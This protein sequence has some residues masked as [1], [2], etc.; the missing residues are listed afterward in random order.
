MDVVRV[1]SGD[2]RARL[3]VGPQRPTQ[4]ALPR[5]ASRSRTHRTVAAGWRTPEL[6]PDTA[7]RPRD[8]GEDAPAGADGQAD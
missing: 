1:C 7:H 2:R 3:A 8:D 6:I 4:R 5:L